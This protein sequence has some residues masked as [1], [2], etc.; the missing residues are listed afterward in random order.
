MNDELIKLL[1]RKL[2]AGSELSAVEKIEG[3]P[4]IGFEFED[5]L[6]FVT[7]EQA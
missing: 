1:V 5:E 4:A 6:Y 7:L 3:E 2:A